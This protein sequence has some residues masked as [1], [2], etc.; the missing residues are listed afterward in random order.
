MIMDGQ[1]FTFRQ[2]DVRQNM[3]AMK[4]GTDGVVHGLRAAGTFLT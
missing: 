1:G 2:F 3:C 4:V